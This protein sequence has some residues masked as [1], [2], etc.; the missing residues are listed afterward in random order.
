M[1][2]QEEMDTIIDILTV[3]RLVHHVKVKFVNLTWTV[4]KIHVVKYFLV[5]H[6]E[7]TGVSLEFQGDA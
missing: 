7:L 4:Y 5:L 1:V 6:K 3:T 2:A